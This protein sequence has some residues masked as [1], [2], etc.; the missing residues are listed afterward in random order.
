MHLPPRPG[1]GPPATHQG[2]H[3]PGDVQV[4]PPV[5]RVSGGE[6]RQA[7]AAQDSGTRRQS[8]A[9]LH[10]GLRSEPGR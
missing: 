8:H 9:V 10:Q 1:A 2:G 7:G 6:P 5:A 4:L 3:D